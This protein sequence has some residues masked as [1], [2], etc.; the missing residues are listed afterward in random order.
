MVELIFLAGV[1]WAFSRG[2][3][4]TRTAVRARSAAARKRT[5]DQRHKR[6]AARQAVTG[7]WLGEALHG[8]PTTRHGFTAGWENHRDA[9][10]EHQVTAA[11]RKA[12]H[13]ERRLG[14]QAEIAAHLHRLEIAAAKHKAGP[15]M[16]AQLTAAVKAMRQRMHPEP[17]PHDPDVLPDGQTRGRVPDPEEPM[18]APGPGCTN[19]GCSCHQDD[20]GSM[21]DNTPHRPPDDIMN[22]GRGGTGNQSGGSS[23][24]AG[25]DINFQQTLDTCDEATAAAEEGFNSEAMTKVVAL[26]DGLGASLRD[27][28]DSCGQAADAAQEAAAVKQHAA[29]LIDAIAALKSGVQTKY[30][31]Q[32]EALEAAGVG[33]PEVGFLER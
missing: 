18:P 19:K 11:R 4:T 9:W 32:Q 30:G 22:G 31:P 27:D 16:S 2:F 5:P 1:M 13:A 33:Q 23:S 25:G 12:D 3:D 26:V 10:R 15:S 21:P 14:W 20:G 8:F 28:P 7:W 6:R 29:A 24:M 17:D